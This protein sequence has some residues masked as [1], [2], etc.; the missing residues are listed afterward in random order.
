MPKKYLIPVTVNFDPSAYATLELNAAANECSI[1]DLVNDAVEHAL[2]EDLE[3]LEAFESRER[4]A[5]FAFEDVLNSINR[6]SVD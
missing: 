5:D 6:K 2:A 3:D 4:E 1:S